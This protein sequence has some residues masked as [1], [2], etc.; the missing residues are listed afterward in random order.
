MSALST[1]HHPA[2]SISGGRTCCNEAGRRQAGLVVAASQHNLA[3]LLLLL[4]YEGLDLQA[5]SPSAGAAALQGW[6]QRQTGCLDA[7]RAQ[8][9][10]SRAC[11][12]QRGSVGPHAGAR[13]QGK[14][15]PWWV[16]RVQVL[17][18]L[19]VCAQAVRSCFCSCGVSSRRPGGTGSAQLRT[20]GRVQGIAREKPP[21][22]HPPADCL[23]SLACSASCRRL[24]GPGLSAAL[25]RAGT[26]AASSSPAGQRGTCR[27]RC[28]LRCAARAGCC[29]AGAA[30]HHPAAAG[31]RPVH[32]PG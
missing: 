5:G 20:L 31:P 11:L 9:H 16:L 29:R 1:E 22:L 12:G 19:K 25:P 24:A 6:G 13:R 14:Q 26:R 15:A 18:R 32:R 27:Q 23:D 8:P 3:P 28:G 4:V 17:E 30:V 2:G 10:K 7:C 21:L